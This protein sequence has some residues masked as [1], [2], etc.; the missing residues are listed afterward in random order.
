[1]AGT[2]EI[3]QT[4]G[5]YISQYTYVVDN[6]PVSN[7]LNS[8]ESIE[9][10]SVADGATCYVRDTDKTWR[11]DDDSLSAVSAT[12]ILPLGQLVGTPGRWIEV[13]SGSGP[14]TVYNQFLQYQP[15]NLLISPPS[16][17][18]VSMIQQGTALFVN[19]DGAN[20]G[21]SPI[22]TSILYFYY[23]QVWYRPLAGGAPVL[24]T[25][26]PRLQFRVFDSNITNAPA[27]VADDPV[28]EMTM[29]TIYNP[30]FQTVKYGANS[31][32]D[33]TLEFAGAAISSVVSAAGVTTVTISGSSTGYNQVEGQAVGAG[34][35]TAF[36]QQSTL[37]FVNANVT[38]SGAVP[39]A[40]VT[41]VTLYNQ[42][43]ENAVAAGFY[44]PIL[45]F[46][47]SLN[48]SSAGGK[49]I[50]EASPLTNAAAWK[51]PCVVATD[52]NSPGVF[53]PAGLIT[54]NGYT[55][56]AG[57]RV[58]VNYAAPGADTQYIGIW[59][60]DA[61]AWTRATDMPAG[62]T[63]LAG[64]QVP[65][66]TLV[67]GT[68]T[69]QS[70]TIQIMRGQQ[71]GGSGS[72]NWTV[73]AVLGSG[74]LTYAFTPYMTG[75]GNAVTGLGQYILPNTSGN[76]TGVS[77]VAARLDHS[78]EHGDM[79]GVNSAT[80]Y[81]AVVTPSTG[82]NTYGFMSPTDKTKLDQYPTVGSNGTVLISNGS[83]WA[84]SNQSSLT[85]KNEIWKDP[86]VTCN[87]SADTGAFP[88]SGL[89]TLNGVTLQAGD[90][91][92]INYASGANS[93][94][95]GI[96][97]AAAGAW[98]RASDMP[99][100][101]TGY[102][103]TRVPISPGAAAGFGTFLST[104]Q[105]M[106]GEETVSGFRNWTVGAVLGGLS[107]TAQTYHGILSG[108]GVSVTGGGL[109]ILPLTDFNREGV[110]MSVARA[111][112]SHQHGN[113]PGVNSTTSYHAVVT[114]STHGFMSP[115]DKTKLDLYPSASGASGNLLV[116]NGSTWASSAQSTLLH[117]SFGGLTSG[118][119]HT[120]Y[121]AVA[122]RAMTGT[123]T[124]TVLAKGN[125]GASNTI[126][127]GAVNYQTGT[128]NAA[129]CTISFTNPASGTAGSFTLLLLQGGAGS[130][131]VTWPAS[132]R[133]SAG[134]APTLTTTAGRT[135]A[136][137]FVWQG[138][139]YLGNYSLNYTLA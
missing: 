10:Q 21:T 63:G 28:N 25:K 128:L 8:L 41:I 6:P 89:I 122:G 93:Q 121:V 105:I 29:L 96:W 22:G 72:N 32:N 57:D 116:S 118:D 40:G 15:V 56:Q 103:G 62:S 78:H 11:W 79:P 61:G 134:V 23:Q 99:V 86:C 27:L 66:A 80:S 48:V 65:I 59:I 120:Q 64:T 26:R 88:P 47:G 2:T 44:N 19:V 50:V 20:A 114:T 58:L 113:M 60:A 74:W 42:K 135:D 132:I 70:G 124:S 136:F 4:T 51:D 9:V 83:T 126:D 7:E 110:S 24:Q 67:G 115:T 33:G 91:V 102:A 36:P 81:H 38:D 71:T 75:F 107:W 92:L 54:I 139:Y 138:T 39:P 95:I 119:P 100:G 31:Y 55:V 76:R 12:V 84:V 101:A 1:M 111:D 109:S 34:A 137:V 46:T 85:A 69:S 108:V 49:T 16:G 30:Y 123:L 90:R 125:L 87:S 117:N 131:T 37:R 18:P 130:N 133:W 104:T 68:P 98:T 77:V 17:T 129:N 94:Y 97:I 3:T 112:H 73:D 43:V 53:P 5:S 45:Q 14:A 13:S 35:P 52:Q 127:W 82:G 106:M